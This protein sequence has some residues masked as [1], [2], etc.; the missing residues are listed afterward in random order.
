MASIIFSAF[1]TVGTTCNS[2]FHAVTLGSLQGRKAVP[3]QQN[4]FAKTVSVDS[5]PPRQKEAAKTT[6]QVAAKAV[7]AEVVRAPETVVLSDATKAALATF[8]NHFVYKSLLKLLPEADQRQFDR[9]IVAF[10]EAA[11]QGRGDAAQYNKVAAHILKAVGIAKKDH[12][13]LEAHFRIA[14]LNDFVSTYLPQASDAAGSH[15]NRGDYMATIACKDIAIR[16]TKDCARLLMTQP[17]FTKVTLF[18][19]LKSM[20]SGFEKAAAALAKFNREELDEKRVARVELAVK[21]FVKTFADLTALLESISPKNEKAPQVAANAADEK[22]AA[23]VA[24]VRKMTR[25]ERYNLESQALVA[26]LRRND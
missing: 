2:V 25:Q 18:Q 1:R 9:D 8:R 16:F 21:A 24:K 11:K 5:W 4:D 23:T 17:D 13:S 7:A 20:I 26:K 19:A 14:L 22:P 12:V 3:A 6:V 15:Q 10:Y